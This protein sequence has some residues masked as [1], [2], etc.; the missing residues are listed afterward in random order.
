MRTPTCGCFMKR[1]EVISRFYNASSVVGQTAQHP[2]RGATRPATTLERV[3]VESIFGTPRENHDHPHIDDDDAA[4]GDPGDAA[5]TATLTCLLRVMKH[6]RP[7]MT[8]VM[9]ATTRTIGLS[10]NPC[11]R[12]DGGDATPIGTMSMTWMTPARLHSS[13]PPTQVTHQVCPVLVA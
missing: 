2:H 9:T 7:K 6:V 5:P 12:P 3:C 11:M 10:F 8:M 1:R 4:A 13:A